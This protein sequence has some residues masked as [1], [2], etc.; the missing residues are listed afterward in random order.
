MNHDQ[1]GHART[2]FPWSPKRNILSH[3]ILKLSRLLLRLCQPA[4]LTIRLMG[5]HVLRISHWFSPRSTSYRNPC[6]ITTCATSPPLDEDSPVEELLAV[7]PSFA[8]HL[9]CS[10]LFSKFNSSYPPHNLLTSRTV[11]LC[12]RKE[13]HVGMRSRKSRP[14]TPLTSVEPK[15][16]RHSHNHAGANDFQ[17]SIWI[18]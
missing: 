3:L 10:T 9:S 13:T 1:R 7:V 6:H 8:H 2:V 11:S 15:H 18:L 17:C 4:V 16:Q 5:Q 12:F 14:L